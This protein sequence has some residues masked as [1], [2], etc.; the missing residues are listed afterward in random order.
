MQREMEENQ[1]VSKENLHP[2]GILQFSIFS[3]HFALDRSE[4]VDAL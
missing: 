2:A 3:F 1:G 4:K